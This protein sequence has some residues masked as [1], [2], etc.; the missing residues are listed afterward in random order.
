MI[1]RYIPYIQKYFFLILINKRGWSTGMFLLIMSLLRAQNAESPISVYDLYFKNPTIINP[2]EVDT[3]KTFAGYLGNRSLT[4]AFAGV[5]RTFADL[6]LQ[7]NQ[8]NSPNKTKHFIGAQIINNRDG[9]YFQRNRFYLRYSLSVPLTN[10]LRLQSGL[11]VGAV[12]YS[13]S[14]S[15]SG[16]GGSD[17]TP[18][19]NLGISL[20]HKNYSFGISGQQLFSSPIRPVEYTYYLRP[21]F[22]VNGS[23]GTDLSPYLRLN[24]YAITE[25]HLNDNNLNYQFSGTLNYQ[26]VFE[27]GTGYNQQK[28]LFIVAGIPELKL[29]QWYLNLN[30]SYLVYNPKSVST[31]IDRSLEVTL[32]LVLPN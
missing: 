5:H 27:A 18:D 4:G 26:Q 19:A 13:F 8:I 29:S 11:S 10:E 31:L 9:A 30:V 24:L 14:N 1:S 23:Y 3:K 17:V 12:N 7:T 28:G 2:S 25:L 21:Y 15:S 22:I 32:G 6:T 20:Q 16:S